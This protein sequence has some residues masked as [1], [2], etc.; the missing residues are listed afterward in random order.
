MFDKQQRTASIEQNGHFLHKN[1]MFKTVY[2]DRVDIHH[3]HQIHAKRILPS[4]LLP[5]QKLYIHI[6]SV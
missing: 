2:C 6:L 4:Y 3:R 5:P 1:K